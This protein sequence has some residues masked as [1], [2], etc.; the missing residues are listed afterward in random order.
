MTRPG[1]LLWTRFCNDLLVNPWL[2]NANF[3]A[4]LL[5]LR[6]FAKRYRTG[7]I[8][9]S[10]RPVKSRTVEGALRAVGQAFASVGGPDP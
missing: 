10:R 7:K 4:V 3:D 1:S 9:P 8:A 2:G 6:V 5:L